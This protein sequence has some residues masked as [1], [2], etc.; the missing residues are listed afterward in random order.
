MLAF[1]AMTRDQGFIT[2]PITRHFC[3]ATAI[4]YQEQKEKR[5]TEHLLKSISSASTIPAFGFSSAH[6]IPAITAG[7]IATIIIPRMKVSK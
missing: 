2:P 5:A 1:V 7:T 4:T 6:A 3:C